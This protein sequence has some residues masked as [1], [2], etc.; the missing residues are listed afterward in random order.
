VWRSLKTADQEEAGLRAAQFDTATRRLFLT[1]KRHGDRM[2]EEEIGA[3]VQ[4]W[5][6]AEL[7]YAEDCRVMAGPV[8]DDHR[9]GYLEGLSIM[10]DEAHEALLG[11][12][13]RKVQK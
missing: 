8:S 1:L 11:N 9:E 2:S 6:E 3:L 10:F 5:L 13:Y 4:Q 7:D 12:D